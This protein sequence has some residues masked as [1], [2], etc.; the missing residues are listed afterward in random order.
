MLKIGLLRANR[1]RASC[2]GTYVTT[3][4]RETLKNHT[5]G[6]A[7]RTGPVDESH[8]SMDFDT[9]FAKKLD[10]LFDARMSN[11]L[12]GKKWDFPDVILGLQPLSEVICSINEY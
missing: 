5:C 3:S 8:R 2:G 12:S 10:G 7:K 6:L 11:L 9:A 1:L 4:E